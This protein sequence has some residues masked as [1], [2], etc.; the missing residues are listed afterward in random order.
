MKDIYWI[1]LL[2]QKGI[3]T[4]SMHKMILQ[5]K[6]I[7]NIFKNWN[8]KYND[9]ASCLKKQL[10]LTAS[11]IYDECNKQNIHVIT[12][13][14][15][16]YMDEWKKWKDFPTVLFAKGDILLLA[17]SKIGVV[18]PRRCSMIA[19]QKAIDISTKASKRQQ[20]V[21]S[22]MAKGIDSYA[23][24]AALK[25]NGSTIAVL[26]SGVDICYPKEHIKLYNAICENGLI[27]SEYLPGTAP[28][29]YN[30]PRRNRIIAGLSDTLY[31]IDVNEK[32]GAQS[33]IAAAKKYDKSIIYE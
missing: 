5:Y 14:S 21:V 20:I 4:V 11:K 10:Y 18:G 22:G 25:S 27:I 29:R 2:L 31:A 24:T 8:C 23:H 7:E 30:F 19:K 17:G 16:Y 1:W 28:C 6:D 13:D 26:G 3:G 32:S 9:E 12:Y 33:T 15:S